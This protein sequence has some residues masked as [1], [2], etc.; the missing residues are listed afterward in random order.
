MVSSSVVKQTVSSQV[1]PAYLG[2]LENPKH[3]LLHHREPNWNQTA[4]SY[5]LTDKK[6][7]LQCGP[8]HIANTLLKEC[9]HMQPR[10]PPDVVWLRDWI[11]VC[12]QCFIGAFKPVLR[13]VHLWLDHL[14]CMLIPGINR[15]CV[16]LLFP[17]SIKKE[18]T[19][20]D[21]KSH[22]DSNQQLVSQHFLI[23]LPC[24]WL[25][26]PSPLVLTEDVHL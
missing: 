11:S 19:G 25:S 20:S 7:V 3:I 9:D 26:A 14:G 23:S 10:P 17:T 4:V 21:N 1:S 5:E 16:L 22:A 8:G 13:A 6:V 15:V 2:R 12:P 24:L 18:M